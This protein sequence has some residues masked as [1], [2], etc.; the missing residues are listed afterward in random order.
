[1]D[2]KGTVG[3][4]KIIEFCGNPGCGK[5]TVCDLLEERLVE[6]GYKVINLQKHKKCDSFV[7]K[8]KKAIRI[9]KFRYYHHNR[10]IKRTLYSSSVWRK[11]ADRIL[12]AK[13]L[14]DKSLDYDFVLF[15]EGCIQFLSSMLD[16]DDAKLSIILPIINS[17][18]YSHESIVFFCDVVIEE[19]IRRLIKRNKAGDLFLSE[20]VGVME[21][22]LNE[23]T[24]RI[25]KA[26]SFC[27]DNVSIHAINTIDSYAAT[28]RC[29]QFVE[30]RKND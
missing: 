26:L 10:L 12:E 30:E 3:K 8:V 14:I 21:N 15:D 18:F 27:W 23:K 28:E 29:M 11:W 25:K 7:K 22:K 24:I 9:A 2:N 4:M 19:N 1:M 6:S 17:R 5:T 20:N 16:L 13:W